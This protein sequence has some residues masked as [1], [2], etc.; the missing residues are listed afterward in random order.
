MSRVQGEAPQVDLLEQKERPQKSGLRYNATR[1][2]STGSPHRSVADFSEKI[3]SRIGINH[4]INSS[5]TNQF[6]QNLIQSL[7]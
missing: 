3:P 7:V 4:K 6:P 5:T 1:H 2:G